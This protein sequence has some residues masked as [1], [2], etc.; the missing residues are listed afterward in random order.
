MMADNNASAAADPAVAQSPMPKSASANSLDSEAS[1]QVPESPSKEKVSKECR[2][3]IA[4]L[5]GTG[6]KIRQ[7]TFHDKA[8]F[9]NMTK[10]A[11]IAKHLI[12][13]QWK[14]PLAD[15]AVCSNELAIVTKPTDNLTIDD[16]MFGD[17]IKNLNDVELPW[18]WALLR[19]L[20]KTTIENKVIAFICRKSQKAF[21]Q[22]FTYL[23]GT[24]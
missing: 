15:V 1:P 13:N 2:T 16:D 11:S 22:S 8:M 12:G 6:Q 24:A 7:D 23:T 10:V 20:S 3:L 21:K 9:S 14:L 19:K 18:I 17:E 4:I 5:N